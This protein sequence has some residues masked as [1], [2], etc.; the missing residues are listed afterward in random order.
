MFAASPKSGASPAQ[1]TKLVKPM[2]TLLEEQLVRET[3]PL[4]RT[5]TEDVRHSLFDKTQIISSFT[6]ELLMMS[7]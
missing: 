1:P 2:K 5:D 7:A 4:L 6:A 3:K